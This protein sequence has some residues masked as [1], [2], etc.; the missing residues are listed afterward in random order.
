MY[1]SSYKLPIIVMCALFTVLVLSV[2]GNMIFF[3]TLGPKHWFMISFLTV[4]FVFSTTVLLA[5]QY[6]EKQHF[7]LDE[8]IAKV[9]EML[10]KLNA[11]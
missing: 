10:D 7:L 9:D 2:V 11:K 1:K 3:N 5:R 6:R 8:A 4:F